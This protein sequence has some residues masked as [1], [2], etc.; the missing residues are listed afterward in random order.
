MNPAAVAAFTLARSNPRARGKLSAAG[1]VVVLLVG[2]FCGRRRRAVAAWP[3]IVPGVFFAM[4]LFV[5]GAGG[6]G[7]DQLWGRRG[8]SG[9]SKLRVGLSG[10]CAL[11]FSC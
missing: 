8:A 7:A 3:P 10:L 5:P 2:S 1:P 6:G 11:P 4:V 9:R